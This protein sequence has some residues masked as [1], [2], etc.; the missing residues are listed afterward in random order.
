MFFAAIAAL[1]AVAKAVQATSGTARR[2][3]V[4]STLRARKA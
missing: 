2:A 3:A 4:W 1:S